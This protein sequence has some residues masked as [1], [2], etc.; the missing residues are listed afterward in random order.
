MLCMASELYKDRLIVTEG[1]INETTGRWRVIIDITSRIDRYRV[2][3]VLNQELA[4]KE[5]AETFGLN[6]AQNWIDQER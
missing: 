4:T 5:E 6:F 1:T 3:K 2:L